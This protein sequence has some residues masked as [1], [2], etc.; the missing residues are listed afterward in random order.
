MPD[1]LCSGDGVGKAF[2]EVDGQT[3]V[4]V[5]PVPIV[6]THGNAAALGES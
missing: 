3:A 6:A 1:T 2:A 4:I 5:S